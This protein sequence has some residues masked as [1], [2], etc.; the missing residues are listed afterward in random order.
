MHT[1][2]NLIGLAIAILLSATSGYVSV[3]NASQYTFTK[4]ADRTGIRAASLNNLG[5]VAILKGQEIFLTNGANSL[6]LIENAAQVLG[7]PIQVP[8]SAPDGFEIALNDA[9]SVAYHCT[10]DQYCRVNRDGSVSGGI[11]AST[12]SPSMNNLGEVPFQQLGEVGIAN[13]VTGMRHIYGPSDAVQNGNFGA[14]GFPDT[15][16]ITD[17]GEVLFSAAAGSLHAYFVSDGSNLRQVGPGSSSGVIFEAYGIN[18]LGAVTTRAF[19]NSGFGTLGLA[20]ADGSL[21]PVT[22][23]DDFIS[24]FPFGLNDSNEIAFYGRHSAQDVSQDIFIGNA[25]GVT[26][27]VGGGDQILGN[28]LDF[29]SYIGRDSLNNKGQI[30]FGAVTVD[31]DSLY[32]A[33]PVPLSGA[34]IFM[35]FGL[36]GLSLSQLRQKIRKIQS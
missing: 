25:N 33:T 14:G 10:T 18:N 5:E 11:P 2:S 31:G 16:T 32:L 19:D 35:S 17:N 8:L 12:N 3:A 27:V 23:T 28:Q 9:G 26:R 13:P 29:I 24:F 6:P 20:L 21:V 15:P 30:L 34:F 36:V 1:R 7:H 22:N 4:I